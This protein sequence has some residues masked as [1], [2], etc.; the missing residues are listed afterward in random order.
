M[1]HK[2]SEASMSI[3][4]YVKHRH[5][6][7]ITHQNKTGISHYKNSLKSYNNISVLFS[8]V[9]RRSDDLVWFTAYYL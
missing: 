1:C 3:Y 5:E 4:Q 8:Y 9:L 2:T 6:S 7:I